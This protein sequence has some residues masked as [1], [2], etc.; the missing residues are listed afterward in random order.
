MKLLVL[1][2]L[3]NICIQSDLDNQDPFKELGIPPFK[4]VDDSI[5]TDA[6]K[7][8]NIDDLPRFV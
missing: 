8:E 4:L 6:N 2:L 1:I 3:V 5:S 7:L